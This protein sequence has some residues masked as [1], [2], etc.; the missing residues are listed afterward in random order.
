M[1]VV[2][3][4]ESFSRLTETFIYDYVVEGQRQGTESWV[5]TLRRENDKDRLFNNLHS[6]ALPPRWNPERLWSRVALEM[7]W[8]CADEQYT[9]LLRRRIKRFLNSCKPDVIHAHFGPAGHLVAPVAA[10]LEL[11]LAVSFYG[12]DVTQ[13]TRSETWRER[14]RLL[15]GQAD[16]LIALSSVMREQLLDLKG[17]DSKLRIVHLAKRLADYP[18]REP[19]SPVRNWMSVGRLTEKKGHADCIKAFEAATRD[20]DV[21]LTIVGEGELHSVLL[22]YVVSRG[23]D[24]RVVFVGSRRHDRVIEM[25]R[26][27]DAFILCSKTAADGDTEGTPTVLLEAQAVG[28]PCV[29]TKHSGIPEVIPAENH[30]FL[31]DE[32]DVLGIAECMKLLSEVSQGELVRISRAGRHKVERAYHLEKEVAKLLEIYSEMASNQVGRSSSAC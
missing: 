19:V 4:V 30:R 23:L 5:L 27:A 6:I 14:Y 22:D 2:H 31:A 13:L 16:A 20:T 7:G 17:S 24:R 28:L 32:G 9:W 12:Y 21:T 1:R 11:P 26:G 3:F 8:T 15:F 18:Y 29:A 25:L 10:A